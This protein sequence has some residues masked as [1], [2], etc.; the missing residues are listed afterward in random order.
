MLFLHEIHEVAGAH[1][2]AFEAS[3]RDVWLPALAQGAD[4]RLLYFL[5]H[6]HGSG[7]SYQ[8]VTLTAGLGEARAE[9]TP[10]QGHDGRPVLRGLDVGETGEDPSRQQPRPIAEQTRD[11]LGLALVAERVEAGAEQELADLHPEQRRLELGGF[12]S[13][14]RPGG[15]ALRHRALPGKLARER[16]EE[17]ELSAPPLRTAQGHLTRRPG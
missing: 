16:E 12:R 17:D 1:E 4:A 2:D 9:P 5:N 7:P 11:H 15:L 6:A 8:V 14:R 13:G 3:F 10:I